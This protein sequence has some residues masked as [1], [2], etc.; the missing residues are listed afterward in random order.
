MYFLLILI[1]SNVLTEEKSLLAKRYSNITEVWGEKTKFSLS[2]S[3][4]LFFFNPLVVAY[5]LLVG[6][7]GI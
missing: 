5:K 4:I 6:A 1:K 7:Y 3:Q 2:L